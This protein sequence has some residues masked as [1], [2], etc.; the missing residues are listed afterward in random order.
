MRVDVQGVHEVVEGPSAYAHG[1]DQF[2]VR[3]LP[4]SVAR[5]LA[6]GEFEETL[7]VFREGS[8]NRAH[9]PF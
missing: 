7:A 9:L 2:I 6:G 1:N 5:F 8:F 4:D 3:G